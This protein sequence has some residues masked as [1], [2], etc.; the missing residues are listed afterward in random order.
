MYSSHIQ[1]YVVSNVNKIS[2]QMMKKNPKMTRQCKKNPHNRGQDLE[3]QT[4]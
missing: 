4:Q 1:G 2:D 3:L